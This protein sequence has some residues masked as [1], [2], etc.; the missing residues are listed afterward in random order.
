MSKLTVISKDFDNEAHVFLFTL[1]SFL[2]LRFL[3]DVLGLGL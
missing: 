3:S 2:L 1:A